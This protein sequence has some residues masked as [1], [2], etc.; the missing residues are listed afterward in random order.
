MEALSPPARE[1]I[2]MRTL[3][4]ALALLLFAATASAQVLAVSFKDDKVAKKYKDHLVLIS[5]EQV[6]VGEGKFAMYLEDTS[7]KYDGA[8]LLPAARIRG[9]ANGARTSREGKTCC[10]SAQSRAQGGVV[11]LPLRQRQ[12][13]PAVWRPADSHTAAAAG[14][15]LESGGANDAFSLRPFLLPVGR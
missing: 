14:S 12:A 9:R 4:T 7:I 11:H 2:R 13:V 15:A 5:G 6:V 8:S 3:L 1:L 10:S